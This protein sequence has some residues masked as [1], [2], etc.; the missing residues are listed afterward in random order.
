MTLL[1]DVDR[2]LGNCLK[3]RLPGVAAN[4]ELERRARSKPAKGEHK[5][6][7]FHG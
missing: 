7:A 4:I 6:P 1:Y 2:I 5:Q 3:V